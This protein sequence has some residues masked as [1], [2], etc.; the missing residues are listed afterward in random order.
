MLVS[1]Q[2]AILTGSGANTNYKDPTTGQFRA[3]YTRGGS[4]SYGQYY[5]NCFD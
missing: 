1:M 3:A 5:E 2:M 4:T